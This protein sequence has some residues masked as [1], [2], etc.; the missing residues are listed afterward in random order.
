MDE[1]YNIIGWAILIFGLALSIYVFNVAGL[2]TTA[3]IFLGVLFIGLTMIAFGEIIKQLKLRN[4][5]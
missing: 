1:I 2:V 4:K 5:Q 3:S